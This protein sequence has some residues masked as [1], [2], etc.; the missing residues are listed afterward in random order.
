MS[1]WRCDGSRQMDGCGHASSLACRAGTALNAGGEW[2]AAFSKPRPAAVHPRARRRGDRCRGHSAAWRPRPHR[3]PIRHSPA[4][5]LSPRRTIRARRLPGVGNQAARM[6]VSSPRKKSPPARENRRNPCEKSRTVRA[7]P[8][9]AR[10]ATGTQGSL[11]AC[12]DVGA[13]A[14]RPAGACCMPDRRGFD[15]LSP[16][17]C[18]GRVI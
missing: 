17:G 6:S 16:N 4:L 1:W 15:R 3:Q 2:P 18:G 14:S 10:S 8:V 13:R 12:V 9:E 5:T 11:I 7:E